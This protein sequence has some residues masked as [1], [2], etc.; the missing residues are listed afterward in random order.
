[1][2][3]NCMNSSKFT[4]L[5]NISGFLLD[6]L[7]LN[8]KQE[9]DFQVN[10]IKKDFNQAIKANYDLAGNIE[11][12]YRL[13]PQPSLSEYI[14]SLALEFE[15]HFP[16][17]S[18]IGKMLYRA[19][20]PSS[21]NFNLNLDDLWVNF[22]KKHE[23]NPIH[24]HGGIFSFVI[25]HDIPYKYENEYSL[26]NCKRLDD[27]LNNCY[28]GDFAFVYGINGTARNYKMTVDEKSNGTICLFPSDLGH[29][30]YPFYTSDEYRI[31]IAG[32]VHLNT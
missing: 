28:N 10:N 19:N 29:M 21:R 8:I 9:L 15:N 3:M 6:T 17:L 27:P 11:Q 16:I 5:D 30:V 23:Y 25:W 13:S 1:M 20:D 26:P 18:K 14:G 31:T 2:I 7:P 22:Q 12:E 4:N 32:N 24:D